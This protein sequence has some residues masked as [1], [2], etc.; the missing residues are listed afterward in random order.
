MMRKLRLRAKEAGGPVLSLRIFQGNRAGLDSRGVSLSKALGP[1]NGS[2]LIEM[3]LILPVLFLLLMGM[4]DFGRGYYLAI[5][6]SHAANAAALYGSQNP[7]DTTG[8]QNAADLDAADVSNFTV[9]S[10][11]VT[12]GCECSD[13]SS[14]VVNCTSTPACA[15]NVVNYVQVNT[16]VSYSALFP[17]PGIPTPL[18]LHGSSRMRAGQ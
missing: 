7:T 4:V 15:T 6:V 13:G 18:T 16:S 5:E 8:M 12:Y 11:T 10:V 3:A 17:Y 9:S 2:S 1:E 14:P